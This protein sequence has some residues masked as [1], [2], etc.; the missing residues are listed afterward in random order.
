[1]TCST[2]S[3][4]SRF[5]CSIAMFLH[6]FPSK[7]QSLAEQLL[8]LEEVSD[9]FQGLHS[10]HGPTVMSVR[11]WHAFKVEKFF[12]ISLILDLLLEIF[13]V[14]EWQYTKV[15]TTS[16]INGHLCI[17]YPQCTD[18]GERTFVRKHKANNSSFG[19]WKN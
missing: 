16:G 12:T 4:Y 15:R 1:M 13:W 11:I 2:Q 8:R 5:L 9:A 19:E 3:A 10:S 17:R 7:G 18:I 6:C 14:P